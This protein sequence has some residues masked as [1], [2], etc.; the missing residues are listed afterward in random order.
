MSTGTSLFFLVGVSGRARA[1]CS[2]PLAAPLPLWWV[3]YDDQLRLIGKG[4]VDFLLVL[5]EI[6]SLGVTAEAPL[7]ENVGS[8]SAIS[9]KRGRVDRISQVEGVALN[10]RSSS[11]KTRLNDLSYGIKIW[12]D[13]SSH[14][15]QCTRL[16]DRR[17]DGRTD[18]IL[19]ARPCLHA[20]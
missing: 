12:T 3:T 4:V 16:T 20:M 13:L 1:P 15:S 10:N 8:K 17:T 2:T 5:I 7:R 18:R 14:L 9:L 19:I 6:C 11:R